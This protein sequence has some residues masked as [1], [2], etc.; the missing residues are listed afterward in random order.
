MNNWLYG[1]F[2][3]IDLY[4]SLNVVFPDEES[5]ISKTITECES[6]EGL[7]VVDETH[8]NHEQQERNLEKHSSP[9]QL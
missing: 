4:Y 1:C 5:L 3:S 8:S 7:E 6:V 9:N 2:L